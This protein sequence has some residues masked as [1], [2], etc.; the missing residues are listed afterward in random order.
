[1]VGLYKRDKD[2]KD[3]ALE[4]DIGCV[5]VLL[6]FAGDDTTTRTMTGGCVCLLRVCVCSRVGQG[7]LRGGDAACFLTSASSPV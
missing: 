3:K 6:G 5:M 2:T 1:M 7:G 4:L